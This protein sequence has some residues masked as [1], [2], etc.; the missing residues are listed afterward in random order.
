MTFF[1]YTNVIFSMLF[2]ISVMIFIRFSSSSIASPSSAS[3]D[4][5]NP[6]DD[7]ANAST[8]D[9]KEE[10]ATFEIVVQIYIN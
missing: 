7:N 8:R 5:M 10:L 9:G 6:K 2:A 4:N 1:V 3:S